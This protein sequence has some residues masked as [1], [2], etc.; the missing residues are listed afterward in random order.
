VEQQC[1]S[2]PARTGMT[3]RK[4][5]IELCTE[6]PGIPEVHFVILDRYGHQI[7]MEDGRLAW[8]PGGLMHGEPLENLRGHY[9]CLIEALEAA[10]DEEMGR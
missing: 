10:Y 2:G 9:V 6:C 5:K 4:F 3:R 8:F 1:F 7:E